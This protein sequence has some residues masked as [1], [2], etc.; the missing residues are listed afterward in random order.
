MTQPRILIACEESGT[1]RRAFERLGFTDVWS[2]DLKPARDG[3]PNHL[4]QGLD[5]SVLEGWDLI[6]AFPPCT[7]L[8]SSGLHWNKRRPERAAQTEE[9]LAFV[10]MI[11]DAP[12]DRIALENP[13]GCISTRIRKPDQYV[14]PWMFGDGYTKKTGFWLKGLP[15]LEP[16]NIVPVTMPDFIWKQP[17]SKARAEIRSTTPAGMAQAMAE[18]WSVGL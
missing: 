6:V 10:Q 5:E 8:C 2:L 11:L 7:Y 13:V 3:S 4:Q 12:C 9:A 16:T 17:E 14:Q 15:L 1:V 18:Q